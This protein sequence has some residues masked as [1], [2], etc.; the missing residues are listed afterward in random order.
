MEE[1]QTS[2]YELG[3]GQTATIIEVKDAESRTKLLELGCIPGELIR[4]DHKTAL[5]GPIAV[6]LSGYKL[7]MRKNDAQHVLVS[8]LV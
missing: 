4:L 7:S 3:L 1:N 6:S 8:P 5:G 2:L